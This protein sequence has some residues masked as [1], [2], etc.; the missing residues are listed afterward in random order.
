MTKCQYRKVT[1]QYR[2]VTSNICERCYNIAIWKLL[3]IQVCNEHYSIMHR[4]LNR[5]IKNEDIKK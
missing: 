3:D 2:K 4:T 5:Y 1:C